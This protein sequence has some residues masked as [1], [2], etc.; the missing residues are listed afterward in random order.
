[1]STLLQVFQSLGTERL[2]PEKRQKD[3]KSAL[4]YLAAA[5]GGTLERCVL[6]PEMEAQYKV[7]LRDY[8]TAQGKGP[9]TV[10]NMIQA[11]GQGLRAYHA[12]LQTPVV[13]PVTPVT[14]RRAQ[15]KHT[16]RHLAETSPYHHA[17]W[18]SHSTYCLKPAQWPA[19]VREG[20][21][22]WLTLKRDDLRPITKKNL[23][24]A[25]TGYVGF[26]ALTPDARPDFLPPDSLKKLQ[27]RRYAHDLAS[28]AAPPV[29]SSWDDLFAVDAV[30]GYLIWHAWR[31]QT[32]QDARVIERPPSFPSCT[33]LKVAELVMWIAEALQ[34]P[35]VSQPLRAYRNTLDEPRRIHNKRAE[36]HQFTRAEIDQVGRWMMEEARNMNITKRWANRR[37]VEFQGAHAASRFQVGL[38]LRLMVRIPLRIRNWAEMLLG[39]NLRPVNG[40]YRIHFEG[41]ELKVAEKRGELNVVDMPI[42][43][44]V[45]DDLREFLTV[46]RPRLP[47]AATERHVFLGS[48][49]PNAGRLEE[50]ELADKIRV[51]VAAW[52][53]KRLYPHLIRTIFTSELLTSG[54]DINTVAYGLNDNPRTVL[55]AYNEL[56]AGKHEQTLQELNR[57]V[58]S[59]DQAVTPTPPVLPVTPKAP[60]A[61]R[62]SERQLDLL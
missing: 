43:A 39:D 62:V 19:D 1:M 57:L 38:I 22:R 18:L 7:K 13:P 30:R 54:V 42:D 41:R 52:T 55:Q 27:G 31:I 49:G 56:Q 9:V 53:G 21:E 36:C 20:F 23:T 34:P 15:I 59:G 3:I 6:T 40:G 35:Q 12:L 5:Y 10:R 37:A 26:L 24:S 28:I 61:P 45:L 16:L 11:V 2:I 14:K 33:G 17:V 58:F 44:D 4:R 32:P 8:L 48:H 29:L 47:A 50:R 25:M 51:H 60:R 46:W